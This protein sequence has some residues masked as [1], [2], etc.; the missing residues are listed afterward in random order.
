MTAWGGGVAHIPRRAGVYPLRRSV[1][2]RCTPPPVRSFYD[3]VCLALLIVCAEC[4]LHP[5]CVALAG[6]CVL[7]IGPLECGRFV[8][9][10]QRIDKHALKHMI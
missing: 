8:G 9:I 5:L 10:P 7:F 1:A 2:L 6:S 4:W 3:G